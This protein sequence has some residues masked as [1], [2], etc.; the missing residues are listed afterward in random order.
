MLFWKENTPKQF[1]ASLIWNTSESL[2]IPLGG[3]APTIFGWMM[4]AKKKKFKQPTN[5]EE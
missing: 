5:K 2:H 4:G 1:I 3:F